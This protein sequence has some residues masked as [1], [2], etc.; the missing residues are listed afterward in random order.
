M[1]THTYIHKL[2][3]RK[4]T[5]TKRTLKQ[6]SDILSPIMPR[7]NSAIKKTAKLGIAYIIIS[8]QF[9]SQVPKATLRFLKIK[10]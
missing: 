5:K 1:F 2:V 8:V 9:E 3:R 7:T 10:R 6:I 4:E